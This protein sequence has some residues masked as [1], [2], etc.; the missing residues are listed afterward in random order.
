MA[1]EKFQAGD[2]PF[3][4]WMQDNPDGFVLNA[5]AGKNSSY[6]KFHKANCHHISG[7]T[8]KHG[9][10]AFTRRDY[11]KICSLS[12]F[13][14]VQWSV[15]NRPTHIAYESCKTCGP[16]VES[17]VPPL[18]EEVQT[19]QSYIEGAVKTISVNAFERSA[20]AREACLKKHGYSCVVCGFNFEA[21]YG[22]LARNYIHVHHVVRLADIGASYQVDPITDLQPVCPNCHAVIHLGGETR[23]IEE[24]KDLLQCGPTDRCS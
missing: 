20:R 21:V 19:P 14:L 18:P 23:S 5:G 7:H 17:V 6:L 11:I 1:T 3:L 13:E 9:D 10:D 4:S 8:S 24:V 22:E 12:I 16:D 15:I 2:G